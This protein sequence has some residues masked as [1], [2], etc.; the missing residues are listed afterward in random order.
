MGGGKVNGVC[1]CM[2]VCVCVS[3]VWCGPPPKKSIGPSTILFLMHTVRVRARVKVRVP[4]RIRVRVEL[5]ANQTLNE[6]E[7]EKLVCKPIRTH[8]TT[9]VATHTRTF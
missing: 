7:H 6:S 2:C 5:S 9:N 4:V 3:R 1:V 8:K